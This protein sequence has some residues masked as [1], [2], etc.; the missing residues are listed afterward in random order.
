MSQK[1]GG[2]CI[3]C[4]TLLRCNCSF[5]EVQRSAHQN[6]DEEPDSAKGKYSHISL[7]GSILSSPC[8]WR[9]VLNKRLINLNV[10]V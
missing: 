1:G 3:C 5:E 7:F 6:A 4:E 9:T 8:G 2:F 10:S